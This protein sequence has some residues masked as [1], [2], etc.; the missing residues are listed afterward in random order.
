MKENKLD[1]LSDLLPD[2]LSEDNLNQIATLISDFI[3][4]EVSERIKLLEAKTMAFIRG[5]ID[6]LKEQAESEITE[7]SELYR[8]AM[9]FRKLQDILG[10]TEVK[11]PEV[12]EEVETLKEENAILI[13]Q[14]NNLIPEINKYKTLA[15]KYKS[16]SV[17][18]KEQLVPLSEQVETLLD[19]R[20][21]FKSSEKA[22]ILAEEQVKDSDSGL[23]RSNPFL[24]E[25]VMALMPKK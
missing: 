18:L 13:Q 19:T 23:D 1:K 25:N 8:D 9:Q 15:K 11:E 10:V 24:N 5:N 3:N 14:I 16:T 6:L 4:E 12:N 2:N 7:E 20:R 17:H 22:L 21:P